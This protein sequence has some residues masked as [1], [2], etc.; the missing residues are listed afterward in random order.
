MA[1]SENAVEIE[2]QAKQPSVAEQDVRVTVNYLPATKAFHHDYPGTTTL[3]TVLT[4]A[5]AFF[6]VKDRQERDKYDYFLE[7]QGSRVTNLSQTL[8]QLL[9]PHRRGAEFNLIERI[10]PGALVA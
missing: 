3:A 8:E 4:D 10:T 9:G 2:E 1:H 5:M 7:F 6:G